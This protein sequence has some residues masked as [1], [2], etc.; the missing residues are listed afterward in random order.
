MTARPQEPKPLF[1]PRSVVDA[2]YR[3]FAE[4]CARRAESVV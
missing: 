4:Y 1:V 2:T 3:S